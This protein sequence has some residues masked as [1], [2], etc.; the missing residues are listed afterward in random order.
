MGGVLVGRLFGRSLPLSE[1]KRGES[2]KK[3]SNCNALL[4]Y[5]RVH[6]GVGISKIDRVIRERSRIYTVHELPPLVTDTR[7]RGVFTPVPGAL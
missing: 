1:E 7:D 6:F 5:T 4:R 2:T 3:E